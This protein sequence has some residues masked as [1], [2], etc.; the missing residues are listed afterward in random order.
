MKE[1]DERRIIFTVIKLRITASGRS[2]SHTFP[3]G[4]RRRTPSPEVDDSTSII[5]LTDVV[6]GRVRQR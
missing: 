3:S 6:N 1:D 5:D 2:T 4:T